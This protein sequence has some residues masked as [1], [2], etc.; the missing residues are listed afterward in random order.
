MWDPR[1]LVRGTTANVWAEYDFHLSGKL[2]H[3]SV[4]SVSLVKTEQGWR[5]AGI[6][7]TVENQ[8]CNT[9]RP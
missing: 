1:V 7:Y 5:I 4:D 8:G 3:C 6:V 2:T 9:R